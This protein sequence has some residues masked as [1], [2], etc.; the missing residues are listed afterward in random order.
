[1][2][3][4]LLLIIA[5]AVLAGSYYW[6]KAPS[7]PAADPTSTTVGAGFEP[8]SSSATFEIDGEKVTLSG[9]HGSSAGTDG[10][11]TETEILDEKAF[12]DLNGDSKSDSVIL[13]ARSG[14]GS[15][16]FVYAAAFVSGT[17]GYK[18][19]EVIF[20]GDRI[21]PQSVSISNGVATVKFL[22]RKEGEAFAAE[23]TVP[24][25][26]QFVYKNGEFREK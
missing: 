20:L 8:D 1:M 10:I 2:K 18:G 22:D 4:F 13:L 21:A 14:G 5:L 25:S 3:K 17:L 15:G 16:V 19:T 26:K 11:A 24:V 9:G 23:P 6:K 12:G 7:K